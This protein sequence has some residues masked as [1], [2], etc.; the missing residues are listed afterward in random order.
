MKCGEGGCCEQ[1]KVCR[2]NSDCPGEQMCRQGTCRD[3]G[4]CHEHPGAAAEEH[5]APASDD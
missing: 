2:L 4:Q 3:A 5:A 1:A